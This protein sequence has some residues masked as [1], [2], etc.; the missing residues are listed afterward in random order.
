[1]T[2]DLQDAV[3]LAMDYQ[4]FTPSQADMELE[5]SIDIE[6]TI[7]IHD[8]RYTR[9]ERI[10]AWKEIERLHRQRRPEMVAWLERK[11]GLSK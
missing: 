1:M 6:I 9:A 11:K 8:Q 5:A 2:P 3:T 10:A 7:C 4:P